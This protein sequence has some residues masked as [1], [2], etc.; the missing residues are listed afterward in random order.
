M[1]IKGKGTPEILKGNFSS[2]LAFRFVFVV[3]I[4]KRSISGYRLSL[5]H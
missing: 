1:E 2:L 5:M 3:R 4:Q